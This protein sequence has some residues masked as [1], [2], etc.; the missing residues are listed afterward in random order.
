MVSKSFG[1]IFD[2]GL[3]SYVKS[4]DEVIADE[5]YTESP[6]LLSVGVS[7]TPLLVK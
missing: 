3:N 7:Y 2:G 1:L 5:N 6:M 4:I